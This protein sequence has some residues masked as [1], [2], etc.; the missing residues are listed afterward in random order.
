MATG[1]LSAFK[2][3]EIPGIEK[4]QGR[5][6]HTA[7]WPDEGVD[8]TG[9]R[10]GVIGTGSSAIQ[11]IPIIARQ[12]SQLTVFQRTPAFCLPAGN[13]LLTN[14]EVAHMKAN[15]RAL[16]EAELNSGAGIPEAPPT[17][18]ALEVSDDER[19]AKFDRCWQNGHFIQMTHSYTDIMQD[20]QANETVSEY[21]REKIRS[22]VKNPKTAETLSPRTYAFGT[23]RV[24]LET[25]Y[26]A[27]F[28]SDH[29]HLVNL[30]ETPLVEITASG[31]RTSE[32]EH[33]LDAIVY[34]T[35]YDAVTGA[36]E[37][38]DVRGRGGVTLKEKWAAGP[39]T[40]LGLA[41]AGFPNMFMVTG[42]Q[43][44]SVFTNMAA[45]IEQHVEWIADCIAYLR[46]EGV[47]EV[48][49]AEEAEAAWVAHA[50]EEAEQK[51]Y[52]HT[53]SWY[54]GSNVPGKPRVL[55]GYVGGFDNYTAKCNDVAACCYQGFV[56]TPA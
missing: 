35:G 40:Y 51:L 44:P 17:Q 29:V 21:V 46:K 48:E 18:S 26:F 14:D 12:A 55:L 15:Y 13:R 3:P 43:S 50:S 6:Y 39:R 30:R 8:F 54:M 41:T 22:I 32:E 28:N 10:V 20:S 1:V 11:S 53:N 38:I 42:P 4:F 31:V 49:A 34:A 9:Q 47:A 27:T 7:N 56:L 5:S 16:R 37:R 45:S 19:R 24:C 25:N 2:M 36:L 33:A 52:M 23:K